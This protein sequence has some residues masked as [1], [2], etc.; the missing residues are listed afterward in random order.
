MA[1][2]ITEAWASACQGLPGL[3]LHPPLQSFPS[4]A[5]CPFAQALC[6]GKRPTKEIQ[7]KGASAMLALP[8]IILG[9]WQ[10]T[11]WL[12]STVLWEDGSSSTLHYVKPSSR[13]HGRAAT[14]LG[15]R[16][17][18]LNMMGK[19]D[20]SNSVLEFN[21]ENISPRP[22]RDVCEGKGSSPL[23]PAPAA[24]AQLESSPWQRLGPPCRC[25]HGDFFVFSQKPFCSI[26]PP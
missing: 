17:P 7:L 18:F 10:P 2:P 23:T 15:Y 26:K 20:K 6:F 9:S 24:A 25:Q 14:G 1:L 11:A 3:S 4:A 19:K 13:G 5:W 12:G 8:L 21:L 16:L 22:L